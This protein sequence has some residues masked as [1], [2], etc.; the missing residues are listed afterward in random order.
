MK[1]LTRVGLDDGGSLVAYQVNP[2]AI[3][4]YYLLVRREEPFLLR[5]LRVESVGMAT[6]LVESAHIESEGAGNF[7]VHYATDSNLRTS[8]CGFRSADERPDPAATPALARSGGR[9]AWPPGHYC[10]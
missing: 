10:A 5:T 1:E 8:G 3:G 7:T 4:H 2:G 9:N 6:G